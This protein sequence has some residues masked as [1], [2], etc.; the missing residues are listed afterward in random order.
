[1]WPLV[2]INGASAR[3]RMQETS[4]KEPA[5]DLRPSDTASARGAGGWLHRF[6]VEPFVSSKHPP[7]FDAR[8]V[9]M[10]LLI[11]FGMPIGTQMLVLGLSRL[12]FRFNALTAFAFTWVNNPITLLPMYYGYYCLGSMIL[13]RPV[14]MSGD[15]FRE[16][17]GPILTASY[18]WDS[19]REFAALGWDMVERW[20]VAAAALA[21]GSSVAGYLIAY[22]LLVRRCKRVARNIGLACEDVPVRPD[23]SVQEKTRVGR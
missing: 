11:G 14:V 15:A 5:G 17:M 23:A 9:A 19:I 21:V 16:L 12:V 8:G 6:F 4:F 3:S 13:G 10:G 2:S 22:P 7:W 20:A 1:V 18:F